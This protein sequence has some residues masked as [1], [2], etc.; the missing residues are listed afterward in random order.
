MRNAVFEEAKDESS[1][2]KLLYRLSETACLLSMSQ[3]SVRRLLDRG[4]LKSNPSLRVKL[5]TRDSIQAFVK[6]TT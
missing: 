3:K 2:T 6:M 1:L 5:I 4:L